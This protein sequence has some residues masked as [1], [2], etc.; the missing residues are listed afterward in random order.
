[1]SNQNYNYI[2]I[3]Q[4][5]SEARMSTYENKSD[6]LENAFVLYQKN[7]DISGAFLP[8]LHICEVVI[9]NGVSIALEE[10]YG[11]NWAWSSSF[12]QS[13]PDP[14]KG[15]NPTND[16]K[17]T[18]RGKN[19]IGN[20]IADLKFVFWQKMF[21]KR[22]DNRLWN[23]YL[24]DIFPNFKGLS[25]I[26]D[27]RGYLHDELESIRILR[28][29]IAHHEPIIFQRNLEDDYNAILNIIKLRC[30]E[31]S[32]WVEKTQKITNQLEI[33]NKVR[34]ITKESSIVFRNLRASY[35]NKRYKRPLKHKK[36]FILKKGF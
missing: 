14:K 5:L 35:S 10:V 29:R 31:T 15:Y 36:P 13:L 28:N 30:L 33:E 25:T 19:N 8:I 18:S 6:T 24:D 27:K 22:H 34:T 7:F 16:L 17:N 2:D 4:A 3:K 26:K 11:K 21:T 12:L 1:M 20:V 23:R 9:R 32:S